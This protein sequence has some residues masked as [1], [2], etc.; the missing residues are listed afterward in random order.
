LSSSSTDDYLRV[1]QQPDAMT[2]P[3]IIAA[4]A[5]VVAAVGIGVQ[6]AAG[7][8]YPTVPP[9][10]II[11]VA[12]AAVC[13]WW[14]RWW[15]LFLPAVAALFLLIGGAVAPNTS[16]NL[17]AGGGRTWGTVLQLIAIVV[18]LAAVLAGV[19]RERRAAAA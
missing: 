11:L 8:S 13:L 4:A 9:G 3:R 1:V 5:F 10:A 6:I 16:D 7:A 19:I 2:T 15:A 12:A 17:D 18:A 14:Q